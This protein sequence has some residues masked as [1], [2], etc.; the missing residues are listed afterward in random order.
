MLL[1]E[2]GMFLNRN[3]R[4]TFNIP[5]GLMK[6]GNLGISSCPGAT[7][8]KFDVSESGWVWSLFFLSPGSGGSRGACVSPPGG[9]F[10]HHF[11]SI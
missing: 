8:V 4:F 7:D 1:G 11:M 3:E 9:V 10:Y 5:L 6:V 2:I